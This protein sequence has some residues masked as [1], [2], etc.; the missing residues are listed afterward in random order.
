MPPLRHL[1]RSRQQRRAALAEDGGLRHML[2]I[3]GIHG[4]EIVH[5][6]E[7][8]KRRPDVPGQKPVG[9]FQ[10]VTGT[11][12]GD[13]YRFGHPAAVGNP[14][15]I[16]LPGPGTDPDFA[17]LIGLGALDQ[18][19]CRPA[20]AG[21]LEKSRCIRRTRR[22]D[23]ADRFRRD[24]SHPVRHLPRCGFRARQHHGKQS[25]DIPG[26]PAGRRLPYGKT[27]TWRTSSPSASRGGGPPEVLYRNTRV[28][29][30]GSLRAT[31]TVCSKVFLMS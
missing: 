9:Q 7:M 14:V 6:Q 29:V 15:T 13:H 2:P 30:P 17:G 5:C 20:R 1:H 8:L 3:H 22:R 19:L 25:R 21:N 24:K 11:L 27:S 28:Q 26:G 31:L 12:G 4:D 23:P 18:D 10:Q 16:G